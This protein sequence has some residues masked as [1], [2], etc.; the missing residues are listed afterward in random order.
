ML[1][2]IAAILAIACTSAQARDVRK[3]IPSGK[4]Q[5]LDFFTSLNPNCSLYGETQVRVSAP[6]RNGDLIIRN[7]SG[8]TSYPRSNQRYA[9][10]ERYVRGVEIFYRSY[11]GYVG[12]DSLSIEVFFPDGEASPSSYYI[13]VR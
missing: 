11:G 3:T 2:G 5:L 8:V 7:G 1:I 6:P 12:P 10:N 13:Q 9:C 4:A